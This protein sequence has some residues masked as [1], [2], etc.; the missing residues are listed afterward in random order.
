MKLTG[1]KIVI[2]QETTATVT[3][4]GVVLPDST[5]E[6]LP[7]GK[8]LLCGP[9]CETLNKGDRVLVDALGGRQILVGGMELL[10]LEEEDVLVIL[11]EGE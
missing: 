8:I 9:D 3:E 2:E 6:K 1:K 7:K 5:V 4:G 10:L 11:G